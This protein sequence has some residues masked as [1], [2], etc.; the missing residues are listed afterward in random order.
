MS[1]VLKDAQ[2]AGYFNKASFLK[3]L[4]LD[5]GFLAVLLYRSQ[6]Y[7][8]RPGF[9]LFAKL[10][11]RVNLSI[12]GSDFVIGSKIGAGLVI[13]H[14]VGI[15]I[16]NKVVCG[17]RLTLMHGVTLG[18]KSFHSISEHD[19]LNPVLGDDVKIGVGAILLG[20]IKV[21]NRVTIAAGTLL[22]SDAPDDT[23]VIGNPHRIISKHR[24]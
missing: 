5:A 20:G 8:S 3:S 16:G 11:S 17:K 7:F 2:A 23:F 15:V 1:I 14:P 19:T 6:S 21:G 4:F 22:D 18:Q 13:R 24:S 9:Y 10:I 12:N